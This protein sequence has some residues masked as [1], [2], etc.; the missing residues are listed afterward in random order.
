MVLGGD[1]N[2]VS[3]SRTDGGGAAVV[4]REKR[5]EEKQLFP[6]PLLRPAATL[7]MLPSLQEQHNNVRRRR[8]RDL[9]RVNFPALLIRPK[10]L[11]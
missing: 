2:G 3:S 4:G 8:A 1:G 10:D 7:F 11:G 5:K 6:I 9:C